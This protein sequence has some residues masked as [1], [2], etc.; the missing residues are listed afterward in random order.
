MNPVRAAARTSCTG[1]PRQF[2]HRESKAHRGGEGGS[3]WAFGRG[4]VVGESGV[5]LLK[6]LKD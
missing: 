6:T 4:M 2:G 3:G 1:G 5:K